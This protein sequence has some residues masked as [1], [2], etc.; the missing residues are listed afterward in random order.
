[1]GHSNKFRTGPK[2]RS[3]IEFT[4]SLDSTITP[5][6]LNKPIAIGSCDLYGTMRE[7]PSSKYG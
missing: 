4:K 1:M 3:W 5:T 2:L 6:K 7:N